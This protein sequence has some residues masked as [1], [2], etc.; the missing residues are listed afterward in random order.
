MGKTISNEQLVAAL[1]ECGTIRDA[2]KSAGIG[3]RTLYERMKNRDFRLLYASA[4]ADILRSATL[5]MSRKLQSAIDAVAEI[6][7]NKE[8]NPATRLQAAQTII[9]S[10]GKI[11]VTLQII[12]E[13]AAAPTKAPSAFDL[14]NLDF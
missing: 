10:A 3:E 14:E 11:G 6:M 9:N 13:R 12:E 5:D 4:K 2:A 8:V 7:T 1:V